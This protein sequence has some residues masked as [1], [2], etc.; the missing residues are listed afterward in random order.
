MQV[1]Q[2]PGEGEGW[3]VQLQR[4]QRSDRQPGW[5]AHL[6]RPLLLP[7]APRAV[8]RGRG[9]PEDPLLVA[10]HGRL[11]T[12]GAD[13]SAQVVTPGNGSPPLERE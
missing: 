1:H 11:E 3:T 12:A 9:A 8:G 7:V 4:G 6:P 13:C 5:P 10:G 2:Q